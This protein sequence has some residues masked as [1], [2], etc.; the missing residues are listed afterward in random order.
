MYGISNHKR[1]IEMKVWSASWKLQVIVY[2]ILRTEITTPV[3]IIRKIMNSTAERS[4]IV[5]KSLYKDEKGY[6]PSKYCTWGSGVGSSLFSTR[7]DFLFQQDISQAAIWCI[8]I[9]MQQSVDDDHIKEKRKYATE[10]ENTTQA[11]LLGS[12]Q[13][14]SRQITW[15]W[16]HRETSD[17]WL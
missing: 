1:D 3:D 17:L 11:T 12:R 15:T 14:G 6:S 9:S 2:E 4:R 7:G 10:F 13:R 5:L 16:E 8:F